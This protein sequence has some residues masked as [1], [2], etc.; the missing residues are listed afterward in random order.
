MKDDMK[1]GI[2]SF[3]EDSFHTAQTQLLQK[4]TGKRIKTLHVSD[5]VSP[6]L[7]K[8]YYQRL[9]PIWTMDDSKRDALYHGTIL[10]E[11]SQLAPFHEIT[12]CY[13]INKDLAYMPQEVIEMPDKER[14]GIVT[15]TLDDLVKYGDDY[16]IVD[17][18]TYNG[19]GYVKTDVDQQYFMQISIYRVLLQEAFEIDAK[20]GCLLYLDKTKDFSASP[21]SVELMD[22]EKTKEYLRETWKKLMSTDVPDGTPCFLCNGKNRNKKIYCEYVD[23]CKI[24][25]N[26][27]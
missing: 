1:K 6:C 26:G 27:I 15:G 20:Y 2:S 17:K 5:F 25:G 9:M 16:V 11:H 23:Q 4:G 24:D 22:T 3:V 8:A 13:D 21:V 18:K 10:H 19:N 14:E 12:M 7:R